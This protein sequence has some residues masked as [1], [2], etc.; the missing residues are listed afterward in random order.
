MGQEG[1]SRQQ[2]TPPLALL[3]FTTVRL[4]PP[5]L[6]QLHDGPSAVHWSSEKR[7]RPSHEPA[8]PV[9]PMVPQPKKSLLRLPSSRQVE[10]HEMVEHPAVPV[11]ERSAQR[12]QPV[13]L[14]AAAKNELGTK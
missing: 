9:E 5:M 13:P 6:G 4:S 7:L 3:L 1:Q 11:F 14:T 2:S 12:P 8:T 10:V